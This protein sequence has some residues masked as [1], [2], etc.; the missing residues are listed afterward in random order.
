MSRSRT[1]R[2][3]PLL[4]DLPQGF[5]VDTAWLKARGIGSKS[6]HNYVKQGWLERIIRGVYRRPLP[7]G[8]RSKE[9]PWQAVILSLQHLM[10][11]DVHLGGRDALDLAGHTRFLMLGEGQLVHLYGDVPSWMK[12]LPSTGKFVLHRTTLFGDDPVG[13]ESDHPVQ[14]QK[15]WMAGVWRWP[16]RVSSPER[17]ILEMIA[18]LKSNPDVEYVDIYFQTLEYLR[19]DLLMKLLKACRSIKT[20]R[21]FF[22]Y[23]SIYQYDWTLELDTDQI[24]LGSGPRALVPGGKFHPKYQ[25]SLPKSFLDTSYEDDCIF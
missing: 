14:G 13:I 6:I 16:M 7:T 19:P 4:D 23:A 18:D 20:R 1:S 3:K 11:Y 21:L 17:A 5:I 2:L 25:I 15:N 12:R 24:N 9:L 22:V 8:A 10:G